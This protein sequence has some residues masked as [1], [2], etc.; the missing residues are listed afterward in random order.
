M[1][2]FNV[3]KKQEMNL[4]SINWWYKEAVLLERNEFEIEEK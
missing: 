1:G 3:L 4:E 2:H